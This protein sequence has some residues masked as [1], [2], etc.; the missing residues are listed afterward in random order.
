MS[1]LIFLYKK[2]KLRLKLIKFLKISQFINGEG[3][4]Q[5]QAT[6]SIF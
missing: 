6:K 1:T 5:S 2:R 4:I 3:K